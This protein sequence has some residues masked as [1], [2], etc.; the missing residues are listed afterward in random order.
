MS[1]FTEQMTSFPI[2]HG[3]L[4]AMLSDDPVLIDGMKVQFEEK[5]PLYPVTLEAADED[6]DGAEPR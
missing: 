4:A 6:D 5:V 1:A 3:G 2:G